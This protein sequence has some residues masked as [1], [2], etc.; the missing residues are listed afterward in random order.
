MRFPSQTTYLHVSLLFFQMKP[1]VFIDTN[2]TGNDM[3]S[4]YIPSLIKQMAEEAGFTYT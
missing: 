3:Y 4:G 2:Q 1:L